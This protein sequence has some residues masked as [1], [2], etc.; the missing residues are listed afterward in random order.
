MGRKTDGFLQAINGRYDHVV[1]WLLDHG[2]SADYDNSI[3]W[4]QSPLLLAA[5]V[6][7]LSITKSLI[8]RGA[9]VT[10]E[11]SYEGAL[12]EAAN[13]GDVDIVKALLDAEVDVDA[14]GAAGY[15]ALT[16]VLVSCSRNSV[17]D[18]NSDI[19]RVVDV[20]LE[21]GANL[22]GHEQR[23]GTLVHRV[24]SLAAQRQ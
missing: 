18:D 17:D 13:W 15:S 10:W 20:L 7:S 21:R 24:M 11:S 16:S 19:V 1:K 5:K 8:D 22:D 14:G 4:N 23:E 3:V 2:A 6:R 9:S 12:H